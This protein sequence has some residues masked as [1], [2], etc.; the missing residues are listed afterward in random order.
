MHLLFSDAISFKRECKFISK[1]PIDKNVMFR[2]LRHLRLTFKTFHIPKEDMQSNL[3][4]SK[5]QSKKTLHYFHSLFMKF[6]FMKVNI[7][8]N[9]I[10]QSFYFREIDNTKFLLHSDKQFEFLHTNSP[11]KKKENIIYNR[12][13]K[14]FQP[15]KFPQNTFFLV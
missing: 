13:Q 14:M 5:W 2:A 6:C 1:T 10:L 15:L 9:Y 4:F 8:L 12:R 3:H 11:K 7:S